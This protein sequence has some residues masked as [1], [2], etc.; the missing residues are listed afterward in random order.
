[1]NDH[2]SALVGIFEKAGEAHAFAYACPPSAPMEHFG[3][4]V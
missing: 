4:I 1:M 3:L 2:K